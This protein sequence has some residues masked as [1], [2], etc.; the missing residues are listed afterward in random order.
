MLY[1][2]GAPGVYVR[3]AF[4]FGF[5]VLVLCGFCELV[6][7][8]GLLVIDFVGCKLELFCVGCVLGCCGYLY[9]CGVEVW[10]GRRLHAV[11][12]LRWWV[13]SLWWGCVGCG[14]RNSRRLG[15]VLGVC[16]SEG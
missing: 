2:F 13:I 16:L 9:V 3:V 11:F 1:L 5:Y 15:G 6:A 8:V 10:V 4:G 14:K 7:I 12:G